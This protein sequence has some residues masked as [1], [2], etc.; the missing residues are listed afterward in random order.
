[1]QR[2]LCLDS[3]GELDHGTARVVIDAALRKAVEDLDDRG[4][5]GKPREVNIKVT[6][7]KIDGGLTSAHVKVAAKIPEYQINGTVCR[8]KV[9]N[10]HS[11]LLFQ[12]LAPDDPDQRT[13]DELA[14]GEVPRG[15]P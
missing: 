5:D 10:G 4:D 14:P 2:T 6:M 9:V 7:E 13:I 3:L 15:E 1:M 12:Q 8:H 11:R